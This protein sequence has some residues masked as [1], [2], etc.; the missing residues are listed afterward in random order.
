[1]NTNA[2]WNHIS[3]MD[4]ATK[5]DNHIHL[6]VLVTFYIYSLDKTQTHSN[7][8]ETSKVIHIVRS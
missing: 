3:Y 8:I 7:Y 2:K 6:I 5:V 4:N 1:M